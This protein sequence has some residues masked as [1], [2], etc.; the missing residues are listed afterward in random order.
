MKNGNGDALNAAICFQCIV[1][2][3]CIAGRNVKKL[4]IRVKSKWNKK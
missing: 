1:P 3:V 4:L 2:H